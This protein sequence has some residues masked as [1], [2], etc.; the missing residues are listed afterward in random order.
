MNKIEK[1]ILNSMLK[2][3]DEGDNLLALS[4]KA[5]LDTDCCLSF[6]VIHKGG[7]LMKLKSIKV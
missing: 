5:V 2:S 3:K 6:E 1:P 4:I 7:E